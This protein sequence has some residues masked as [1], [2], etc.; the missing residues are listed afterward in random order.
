L[1]RKLK[2]LGLSTAI[3]NQWLKNPHFFNALEKEMKRRF[4]GDLQI[5]SERS[6]GSLIANDRDLGAIKYFHE[7]TG[8]YR[9]QSETQINLGMILGK[10]ME[11]LVRFVEPARLPELANAIEVEVLGTGEKKEIEP[12]VE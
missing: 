11:V 6:L 5:D 4:N 1:S 3:Y 10:L 8:R 9:P 2:E 12:P 7:I